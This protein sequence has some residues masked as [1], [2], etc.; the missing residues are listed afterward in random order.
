MGF[1]VGTQE[2]R[3]QHRIHQAI[4]SLGRALSQKGGVVEYMWF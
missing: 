2:L 3:I 4:L 1:E